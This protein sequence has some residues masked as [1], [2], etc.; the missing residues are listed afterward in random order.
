MPDAADAMAAAPDFLPGFG[1]ALA[2]A[3]VR[4]LMLRRVSDSEDYRGYMPAATTRLE[5]VAVHAG[6]QIRIDES[7]PVA[8]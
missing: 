8:P 6:E 4:K 3:S 7:S 2:D 5:V 1:L